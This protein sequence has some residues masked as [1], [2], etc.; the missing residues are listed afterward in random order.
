[1]VTLHDHQSTTAALQLVPESVSALS[2]GTLPY[3]AIIRVL[4]V[5]VL[6]RAK[7]GYTTPRFSKWPPVIPTFKIRMPVPV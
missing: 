1:M 6:K 2:N 5:A 4:L 3:D 7:T